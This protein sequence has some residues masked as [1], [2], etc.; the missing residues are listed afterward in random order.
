MP[1]FPK[2]KK[3]EELAVG[4]NKIKM[5]TDSLF[6]NIIA[7]VPTDAQNLQIG[8]IKETVVTQSWK[9]V[10]AETDAEFDAAWKKL[11]DDAMGLGAQEIIDWA[12]KGYAE[13]IAARP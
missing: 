2:E 12:V 1:S 3:K 13:A 7:P 6:T 9:C 11:V 8:S 4:E 5:C 10:Y